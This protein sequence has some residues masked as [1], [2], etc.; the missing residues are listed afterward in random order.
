[1][2]GAKLAEETEFV[3]GVGLAEENE[4]VTEM[5]IIEGS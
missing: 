5:E 1:M 4:L 3:D 2:D